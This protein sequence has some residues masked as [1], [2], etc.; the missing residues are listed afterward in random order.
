[1]GEWRE[2]LSQ[3][4]ERFVGE[5]VDFL[6]IPSISALP[7]HSESVREAAVWVARRLEAAGGEGVEILETGGHPVVAGHWLHGGDA[8]PTVL[9]YGHFDVQPVDPVEEWSSPP[10]EPVIREARVFARGASD[11]KG[12]MLV[13]L[14]A[15]E[16]MRAAGG[17]L[18]NL[19]FLFEGQEEIGSPQ[20]PAFLAGQRER[21]AC[22]VVVSADGGQWSETEPNLLVG[23]KGLAASEIHVKGPNQDLHSGL[24]GGAV[25]NPLHAL[26]AIVASMRAADGTIAVEGFYDDVVALTDDDRRRIAIVPHDD[27][28]YMSDLDVDAVYGEPD[29]STQ[30]RLWSRPTLE[31]NGMWG[32]F[33]GEGTKTVIPR[34]AHAKI[35]CRLVP[36]QDPVRVNELL[37]RHVERHAPPG[38]RVEHRALESRAYP[39][40]MRA[41]HWA[42]AVAASVL[43]EIY[44]R[45]P[46]Y[47]RMGGSIPVCPLFQREL[48]AD[49]LIFAFALSD[50]HF[51]APDEFFRL[52]SFE[53]G[54]T[55]WCRLFEELAVT[56]PPAVAT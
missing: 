5:L 32:G 44:G 15:L 53:R 52:A 34:E 19:K 7:E 56:A 46:Y 47:T 1:M 6:R 48:G 43:E 10:F 2:I 12:N 38:V 25:Q 26:A 23:L 14:I 35:T 3:Q 49:T 22:D 11:D 39:Y 4:R 37:A 36:D 24:H 20:L 16:A 54:Q 9:V 8:T 33:Q 18:P 41:D 21:F 50:E 13:P 31:I 51:H 17:R 42:N 29:Y 27:E 40:V 55:A 30:Q 28:R 45:E